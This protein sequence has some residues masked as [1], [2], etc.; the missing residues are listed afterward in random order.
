MLAPLDAKDSKGERLVSAG[1]QSLA[2]P[3]TIWYPRAREALNNA[4]SERRY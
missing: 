4:T 3:S 1:S 2:K